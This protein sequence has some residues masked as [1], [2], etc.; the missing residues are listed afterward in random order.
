MNKKYDVSVI[1]LGYIG[2]PLVAAIRDRSD[3]T[4]LGVDN[5]PQR[6]TALRN[7]VLPITEPGL[8]EKL[9]WDGK[10]DSVEWSNNYKKSDVIVITVPTPFDYDKDCADLSFIY[11][12]VFSICRDLEGGELI[13]IESTC[14]VGT[15]EKLYGEILRARP[16]LD[17]CRIA[18]HNPSN[19]VYMSYCPERVIPGS[20]MREIF[21][22]DRV[23][24]GVCASSA[25]FAKDFYQSFV[26][27][28]VVLAQ[29][30][31]EAEMCKLIENASRDVS[32]AF[33]NEVSNI[34]D[35]LGVNT[36]NVINLAN[37]HP[38][39]NILR[40]GPGVGGHCIA[41]DPKFI[42]SQSQTQSKLLKTAREVNNGRPEKYIRELESWLL[43]NKNKKLVIFG[44]TYKPDVDDTR[45]SPSLYIYQS[46][47]NKF[48]DRV[49]YNDPFVPELSAEDK[50]L[51]PSEFPENISGAFLVAHSGFAAQFEFVD[52]VLDPCGIWA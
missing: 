30:S 19:A 15:T 28:N 25:Q 9:F 16:D 29:T 38:R 24:G 20:T 50:S 43:Q 41:V 21:Q 8:Y 26:S 40:P 13:I 2:L 3:K 27:G 1:G 51:D 22:N 14:P 31:R 4:I 11:D 17:D 35:D 46:L 34:C 52:R 45:E 6:L 42:I 49:F 47:K 7:G 12:V 48:S 36:W 32:I 33:A 5:N 44:I 10:V 23:V 18:G 37:M 39:V